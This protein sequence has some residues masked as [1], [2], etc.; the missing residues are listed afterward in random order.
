MLRYIPIVRWVGPLVTVG[1]FLALAFLVLT[2]RVD[3]T[4]LDQYRGGGGARIPAAS[5]VKLE[6]LG[7]RSDRSIRIASFHV[8]RFDEAKSADPESMS[9]LASIAMQFDLIAIQG[10]VAPPPESA[11]GE[12]PAGPVQQLVELI[13][14]SGGRYRAVVSEPIGR[15]DEAR[16]YAFLWD[17]QR[18]RL[19]ADSAYVVRDDN[20]R[21]LREPM[22]ATFQARTAAS[23]GRRPFAFTLVNAHTDPDS[24]R[25]LASPANELNVLDDVFHRVR[26]FEY[27]R[28]ETT[29]VILLG[30]LNAPAGRL[31]EL[32]RIPS[33]VNVVSR[34]IANRPTTEIAAGTDPRNPD[35]RHPEAD[36]R[37]PRPQGHILFDGR[38]TREATGRGGVVDLA[39]DLEIDPEIAARLSDRSPVWA[40]FSAYAVDEP[41][42]R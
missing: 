33:F 7:E 14:R 42:P 36:T 17:D 8:T 20:D 30:D 21:M 6:Q 22:V 5:P 32:G 39:A 4:S 41:P 27:R 31:G 2:G 16:A 24:V 23:D 35:T 3:L 13:N 11:A 1:G 38:M 37:G 15:G 25:E 10:V 40:E 26:E 28:A 34:A 18:I 29:D 9:W 12:R 19:D